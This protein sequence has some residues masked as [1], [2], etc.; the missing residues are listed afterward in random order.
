MLVSPNMSAPTSA[1]SVAYQEAVISIGLNSTMFCAFL[2]GLCSP[3]SHFHR[4]NLTVFRA[5]HNGLLWHCVLLWQVCLQLCSFFKNDLAVVVT[6][7]AS[8]AT[9]VTATITLLYLLSMAQLAIVWQELQ[10]SFVDSGETRETIFI[11]TFFSP[12]WAGLASNIFG[13]VVNILAD[14]LLV[15]TISTTTF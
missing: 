13:A 10:S 12:V 14:G 1:P 4:H 15:S 6:R 3:T 7:K 9:I 2:M 8:Q 11:T 5:L